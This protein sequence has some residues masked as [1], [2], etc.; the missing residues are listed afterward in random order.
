MALTDKDQNIAIISEFTVIQYV[1]LFW[2]GV[3][4]CNFEAKV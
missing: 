4:F 3:R 1:M 2:T